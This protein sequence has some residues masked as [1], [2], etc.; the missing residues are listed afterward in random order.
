[1]SADPSTNPAWK[2]RDYDPAARRLIREYAKQ[3]DLKLGEVI[4]QALLE[5]A[6]PKLPPAVVTKILSTQK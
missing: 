2:I 4:S 3:E 5:Y 6:I 1:M